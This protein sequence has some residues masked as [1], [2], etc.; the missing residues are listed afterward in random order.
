MRPF[1]SNA[2][3]LAVRPKDNIE[4]VLLTL[5]E[6]VLNDSIKEREGQSCRPDHHPKVEEVTRST[7]GTKDVNSHTHTAYDDYQRRYPDEQ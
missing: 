5:F 1:S 7:L 3:Q 6:I 4:S 2:R